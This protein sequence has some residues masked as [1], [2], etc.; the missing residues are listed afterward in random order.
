MEDL[1]N[2]N[3]YQSVEM[4][5]NCEFFYSYIYKGLEEKARR[6]INFCSEETLNN[7]QKTKENELA[8]T[9]NSM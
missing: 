6:N 9:Y 1:Y 2:T 3:I 4:L 8:M 7:I 5:K